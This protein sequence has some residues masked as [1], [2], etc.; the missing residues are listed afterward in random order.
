[1]RSERE[2]LRR[3]L[4]WLTAVGLAVACVGVG[5]PADGTAGA[6]GHRVWQDAPRDA[7][8][9]LPQGY[10][11]LPSL[12]GLVKTLK[13]AVVNIYTTQVFKPQRRGR[14]G[15]D[16][17]EQ[18][19]RRRGPLRE[20]F[21]PNMPFRP[22]RG[23]LRRNSLGSGFV[24]HPDG[25]VISNHHVVAN[26]SAI[27]VRL[28][29]GDKTYD[30][31][32]IGSDAKTDVALLKIQ[33]DAKLP[34]VELGDSDAL[35]VGDWVVAIGNPFGL[36]HT[37]TAGIISAKDRQIGHGP[38]DDFLQTDAAINPGNSGGPLFDS[39][40]RV[41]GI[42]TAIV[43]G[44][45]GIGFAV[46]I[47]L[48]KKLLPQLHAEGKVTRGWLGVGIQ[49]L[50]PE[51]AEKFE[52]EPGSG[53]L[54]SQVFDGS[55]AAE[56]GFESG[57]IILKLDGK[58]VADSHALTGAI[59]DIPPG[60]EVRLEVL[61]GGDR[62]VLETELGERERGEARALGRA[63]G[64][65]DEAGRA[66]EALGLEVQPLSPERARRLGLDENLQGLLVTAV[67]PSGP[68]AGVVQQRD[69]ILEINRQ[70][71]RTIAEAQRALKRSGDGAV[72]LRLQRGDAQVYVVIQR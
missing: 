26:A 38:Y 62:R 43:A 13:P 7:Q 55:P 72:L 35:A 9:L 36:G 4:P 70:R 12:K 2:P 45:S 28:A 60:T 29:D 10:T 67:D 69:V 30:A 19:F 21:G 57:D 17:F 58:P 48:A 64:S 20:F 34:H 25:Y 3:W 65:G 8:K 32:V 39:A 41:V 51:L 6:N 24:V 33:P 44:G 49:D 61:R 59:A 52:V 71:V 37:V 42:N 15:Q 56:A 16:P 40:G 46:P 1:M 54:V 5:L 23:E 63:P 22:P 14:R 11:P 50:T 68:A 27:K 31:K 53:V 47:N 66:T 18:F